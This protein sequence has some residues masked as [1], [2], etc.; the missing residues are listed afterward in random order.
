MGFARNLRYR[1][2]V[3]MSLV[4]HRH[5]ENREWS[6]L[7]TFSTVKCY[8]FYVDVRLDDQCRVLKTFFGVKYIVKAQVRY[9]LR[10]APMYRLTS[11][12]RLSRIDHIYRV[13]K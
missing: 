9:R 1:F 6:S 5:P 10:K 8:I 4:G 11:I 13:V 7:A 3:D 12:Y 2:Y